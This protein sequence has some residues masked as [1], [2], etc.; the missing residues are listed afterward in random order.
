[1]NWNR[2]R[3]LGVGLCS[4]H[5][6][7]IISGIDQHFLRLAYIKQYR[8]ILQSIWTATHKICINLISKKQIFG[9]S[10][11]ETKFMFCHS[12]I[13]PHSTAEKTKLEMSSIIHTLFER[14]A[15]IFWY[16]SKMWSKALNKFI[17]KNIN[18]V[19]LRNVN[20]V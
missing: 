14:S 9:S 18:K 8:I 13:S 12:N 17:R 6:V 16:H 19:E 5:K 11:Q 4:K 15:N 20:F 3:K 7:Y 1:M 10:L 2:L